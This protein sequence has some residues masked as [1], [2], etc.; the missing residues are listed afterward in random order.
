MNIY[1]QI[2]TLLIFYIY[3]HV[4][5]AIYNLLKN[6]IPNILFILIFP[7]L[8]LIFMSFL[9]FKNYGKIHPYF[10]ITMFIG[11]LSCKISVKIIKKSFERLNNR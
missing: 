8:T 3:G 6:K 5:Y 4:V 9:Y 7:I 11:V 1:D 2:N 10:I